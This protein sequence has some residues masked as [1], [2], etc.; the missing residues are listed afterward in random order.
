MTVVAE[1]RVVVLVEGPS[2]QVALRTLARRHDRDLEAEGIS[3]VSIGGAMN[4]Q[5]F[6]ELFGAPRP[7]VELAGLCDA[8][9][10]PDFARALERA[11]LGTN[12][13]RDEMERLG[14]FVCDRDLEDELI[15]AL[16]A[17]A[18]EEALAKNGELESFRIL[19]RQPAWRGQPIEEQ[20]HRFLRSQS[21]RRIS[22]IQWLV[23]SLALHCVPRPLRQLLAYLSH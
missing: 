18:V 16:G 13:S 6:L 12:L 8:G 23:E 11:G 2:D 22:A 9:E 1:P 5:T 20:L 17:P 15:R 4:I 10:A 7:D 14:F 19:Q 3:I 21:R